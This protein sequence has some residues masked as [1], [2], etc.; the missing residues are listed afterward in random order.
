MTVRVG[1]GSQIVGVGDARDRA[2]G[3]TTQAPQV[4]NTGQLVQAEQPGAVPL[5]SGGDGFD[6][7][8]KTWDDAMAG[9]AGGDALVEFARYASRVA[10]PIPGVIADLPP[11]PKTPERKAGTQPMAE[12]GSR[13]RSSRSALRTMA[14]AGRPP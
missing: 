10:I 8:Q 12:Q 3:T 6:V 2:A 1:S 4:P 7:D 9:A 5:G 14:A 11:V 13:T